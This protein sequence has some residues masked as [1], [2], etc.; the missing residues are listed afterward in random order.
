MADGHR[1]G[2]RRCLRQDRP[3]SGTGGWV[4][5]AAGHRPSSPHLEA[6]VTCAR[7]VLGTRLAAHRTSCHVRGSYRKDHHTSAPMD[8]VREATGHLSGPQTARTPPWPPD[9][10]LATCADTQPSG[11]R[12]FRKA[13]D[14]QSADGPARYNFLYSPQGRPADGLPQPAARLVVTRTPVCSARLTAMAARHDHRSHYRAG[15]FHHET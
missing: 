9:T 15:S 3:C 10:G 13:A 12:S 4:A 7:A 2:V 11:R 5:M 1:G 14:G 8:G 6:A